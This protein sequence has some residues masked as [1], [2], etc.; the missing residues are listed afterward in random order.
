MHREEYNLSI[1]Y[2]RFVRP[3]TGRIIYFGAKNK[4]SFQENERNVQ[5]QNE[6]KLHQSQR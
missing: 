6:C 5:L 2:K 1:C 3:T 4:F